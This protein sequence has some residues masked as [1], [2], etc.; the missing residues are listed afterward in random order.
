MSTDKSITFSKLIV[1]FNIKDVI[2]NEITVNNLSFKGKLES[3][4]FS[5]T[6]TKTSG[7]LTDNF[8]IELK[9]L[10]KITFSPLKISCDYNINDLLSQN[11]EF[12]FDEV[13]FSKN[14]SYVFKN[15]SLIKFNQSLFKNMNINTE[16]TWNIQC[17]L[18]LKDSN[19]ILLQPLKI[20]IKNIINPDV[21]INVTLTSNQITPKSNEILKL[22]LILP[23]ISNKK[24]IKYNCNMI[25]DSINIP[26]IINLE[27]IDLTP[28]ETRIPIDL[29]LSEI[30]EINWNQ[31]KNNTLYPIK[32]SCKFCITDNNCYQNDLLINIT[33]INPNNK[34]D[35]S[36]N[37]NSD[38]NNSNN[39]N[40]D[41]KKLNET[42]IYLE[43]I[44]SNDTI[45]NKN[46]KNCT[47]KCEDEMKKIQNETVKKLNDVLNCSFLKTITSNDTKILTLSA[48]AINKITKNHK[49]I[50]S[51]SSDILLNLTDCLFNQS[52]SK[53][54]SNEY[55]INENGTE[56]IKQMSEISS[57]F[58]DLGYSLNYS[59]GIDK[60]TPN[61]IEK[62]S[63]VI[64]NNTKQ[65]KL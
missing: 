49:F 1:I 26:N 57:N 29:S 25:L 4:F 48:E 9:K 21:P 2:K 15:L 43:N 54:F 7:L 37:N 62:D 35:D 52:V 36:N 34:N 45:S 16:Y 5:L 64:N 19:S 65:V 61:S 3:S 31:F 28:P 30:K 10:T 56:M 50:S 47:G 42:E 40:G 11:N 59:R 27:K 12:T 41:R 33:Y 55:I 39:N 44:I 46:Q 14:N 58:L 17:T 32:F 22:T 20:N 8:D 23:D 38:N 13:I 18:S 6:S 53:S 51:E 60:T 24:G 63:L